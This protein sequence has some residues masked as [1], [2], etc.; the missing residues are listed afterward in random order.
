MAHPNNDIVI[1]SLEIDHEAPSV[2]L[3]H[4]LS[5]SGEVTKPGVYERIADAIR[6]EAAE[7]PKGFAHFIEC[8]IKAS[9]RGLKLLRA[10]NPRLKRSPP[11]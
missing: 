3:A 9:R 2:Y 5:H 6:A 7:V 8:G 10:L 1:P 4:L 11:S